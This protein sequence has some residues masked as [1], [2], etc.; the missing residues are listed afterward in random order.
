MVPG[1]S[2]A[3]AAQVARRSGPGLR[4]TMIVLLLLLVPMLFHDGAKELVGAVRDAPP[5]IV[6]A[7]CLLYALLLA[8]PFVPAVE[9]GLAIMVMFGLPGIL[10]A[11]AATFFGLNAA[12][13]LGSRIAGCGP[14]VPAL[15]GI[16]PERWLSGPLRK[17]PVGL[18]PAVGLALLLNTPGNAVMGGGGGIAMAYGA[19]RFLSWPLFALITACATSILPILFGVGLVSLEGLR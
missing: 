8:V 17:L 3:S 15:A 10:G 2:L 14:V 4:R 5:G 7:I 9:I 6:V 19:G 16:L 13:F 11:Y 12:Y 1:V 18:L